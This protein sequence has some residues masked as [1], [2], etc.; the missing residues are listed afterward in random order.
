MEARL[1]THLAAAGLGSR[2]ACEELIRAG[3]VRVNGAVV[4]E[5]GSK[6][7]PDKDK[8]EVSGKEV[9]FNVEHFYLVLNKPTGYV[10]TVS[11]PHAKHTVMDLVQGV[12]QR[13]YPVGR[14]DA[15]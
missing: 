4:T 12:G 6:I 5:L 15:D 8:I 11:D 9:D 14:L 13:V 3:K 10:T 7:D 2:R 1:Q